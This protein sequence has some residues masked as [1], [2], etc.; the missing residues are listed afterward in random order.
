MPV[1][2]DISGPLN[3]NI[4][5]AL[6]VSQDLWLPLSLQGLFPAV[7]VSQAEGENNTVLKVGRMGDTEVGLIVKTYSNS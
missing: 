1:S 3:S 6:G 5:L 7:S 2:M 4:C